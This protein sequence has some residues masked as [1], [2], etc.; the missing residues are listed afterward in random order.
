MDG[1]EGAVTLATVVTTIVGMASSVADSALS[2]INQ[3]LPVLAPITAAII[4]AMLGKR[5]IKRFA[6]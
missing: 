2:L 4:V 5:V 3:T 6:S 1:T